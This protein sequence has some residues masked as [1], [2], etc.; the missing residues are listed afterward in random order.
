M[1]SSVHTILKNYWGTDRYNLEALAGDAGNRQY[2]RSSLK[3]Q[4]IVLMDRNEPYCSNSDPFVQLTK[5]LSMKGLP[6]PDI[7]E[8]HS[9]DGILLIEDLG[10]QTLQ[11]A[12][13]LNPVETLQSLYRKVFDILV[14]MHTKCKQNRTET[15]EKWY[16]LRFD[17]DKL[18][19]EL[20]FFLEHY[21]KKHRHID[22][23]RDQ[24]NILRYTFDRICR[25]LHE[26][27]VVFTHRDFHSR[28]IMV[29]RGHIYLIDY[30]DARLG[31]PEYDLASLLRDAYVVL[32]ESFIESFLDEY[33]RNTDDVRSSEWRRYIFSIMCV[34]RNLKALGSFGFQAISKN[35]NDYLQYVP[36]LVRHI[37]HELNLL[38]S[39]LRMHSVFPKDFGKLLN[40][41]IL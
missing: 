24:S 5:Y 8:D 18:Y 40:E 30:Q 38:D 17:Y 35:N 29:K 15:G 23:S 36:N 20:D 28:N 16:Q 19:W 12:Y 34:Q 41:I 1:I 26:E 10:N 21:V 14:L 9:D 13:T 6:V 22:L 7:L 31:P 37:N 27:D 33:Y 39:D 3:S 32:P 4:T 11:K 2:Y 25:D